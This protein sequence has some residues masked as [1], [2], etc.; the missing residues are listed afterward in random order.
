MSAS[1]R[2]R[3][4]WRYRAAGADGTPVRGEID[5]ATERDA[6]DALRRQSLWV[7]ELVPLTGG[8][9]ESPEASAASSREGS[10]GASAGAVR[11]EGSRLRVIGQRRATDR[12]LA[13]V[14]RAVATLLG[15]GVPLRR[16]LVYASQETAG[17]AHR[18][19]FGAV[20]EAIERGSSL[21]A[22]MQAQSIF[23]NTF[24]PIVA[25]GEASG[26]LDASLAALADDLERRAAMRERITSALL[27]PAILGFASI[28]GVV[29]ILLVVVPRFATLIADGGGALPMSTRV[30]IALSAVLSRGWWIILLGLGLGAAVLQRAWHNGASRQRLDGARLRWPVVGALERMH[31]AAGYVGTFAM[32][33]RAGVAVL[34][35]MGLSREV[36][37]NQALQS[38]LRR[39]EE[40]V[41]SGSTIGDALS[42]LLPPL[43]QRLLEA[44]E[45][46]G[47]LAG[48]A[49]RAATAADAEVQRVL[50]RAVALIEPVMILGF[51]GVVG[52]V[53]LALLQAI[54]GLNASVL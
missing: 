29:V 50:T 37:P 14:M 10:E 6:V 25:A 34:P 16:A 41:R 2:L 44:G 22:A 20:R 11:V 54:Y 38:D 1:A 8:G 47:D 21:S 13:V 36:V 26:T 49:G 33:L 15:A 42:G 19:A 45:T 31:A 52:F 28:V 30:L 24:A 53:A 18:A 39:A 40:R 12:D 3:Q 48:M 43:T 9:A 17:V 32:A 5:A 23:P 4:R 51:G 7:V 27:Y 46:S 35:A